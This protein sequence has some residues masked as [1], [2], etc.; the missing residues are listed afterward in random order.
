[1]AITYT[2]VRNPVWG[3]KQKTYIECEVN[4]DHVDWEEWSPCGVMGSGDDHHIHE[5]F[6][7]CVAGD[8]GEIGAFV[9][10]DDIPSTFGDDGL[11]PAI[12]FFIRSHRNDLLNESDVEMLSDRYHAMT[13][14]KQ[15]EWTAYRQTLRDMPN[16]P[17][18]S[19]MRGVFNEDTNEFE[20][21]VTI[22][23]PT[24]PS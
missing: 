10:P 24:K 5:I 17:A 2:N 1:M 9:V 23:W 12:D 11:Q 14:E 7:R 18:Y 22:N 19:S 6:N 21:T 16:D 4:W 8:F 13:A 15:Q 3:N 20:P